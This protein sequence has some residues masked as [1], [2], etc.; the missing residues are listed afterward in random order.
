M[1]VLIL[2]GG[3]AKRMW[4]LTLKVPK[5]LLK[6]NEKPVMNYIIKN[7]QSLEGIGKIYISTNMKFEKK[8]QKWKE[9]NRLNVEIVIEPTTNE[10]HKLGVIGSIQYFIDRKG[11][12]NDLLVVA[13]DNLFDFDLSKMIHIFN[14][15]KETIIAVYNVENKELVRIYSNAV[16]DEKN[17]VIE[18]VEK[19]ENPK[20][21]LIGTCCYIFPKKTL[22]YFKKYLNEK[23]NPDA[24]GYFT[25]W[26][27]KKVSVFACPYN[28]IWFDI[29]DK[30]S[31]AK[32]N[33]A[34]KNGTIRNIPSI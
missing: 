1:D 4:P 24:I 23:N 28:G 16:V 7:I 9:K 26:L 13:G 10:N 29:G 27:H 20:S 17:K 15:N 2:A 11:F 21:C 8:F 14:K 30:T 34:L 25:Q 32:A 22:S 19:P 31:L 33:E 5:P 12:K 3:Y 18:F 6:V